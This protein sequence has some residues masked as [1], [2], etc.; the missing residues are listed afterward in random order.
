MLVF[1]LGGMSIK[2]FT[3]ELSGVAL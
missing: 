1:A 3:V 2:I